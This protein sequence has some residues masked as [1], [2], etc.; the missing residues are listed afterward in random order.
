METVWDIENAIDSTTEELR[1]A[2]EA[3]ERTPDLEERLAL[4]R[5]RLTVV[6]RK[7]RWD[8]PVDGAVPAEA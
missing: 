2:R 7:T 6:K 1:Q 5:D 3:S 4:L 8:E